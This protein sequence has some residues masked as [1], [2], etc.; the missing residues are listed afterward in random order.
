MLESLV[1]TARYGVENA[2]SMGK[3]KRRRM[4]C[5]IDRGGTQEKCLS[6]GCGLVL[7][8]PSTVGIR[9]GA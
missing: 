4:F 6:F 8:L 9:L 5:G 3:G 2:G 1:T 7:P